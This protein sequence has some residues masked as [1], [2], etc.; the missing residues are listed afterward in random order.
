[1]K[2]AAVSSLWAFHNVLALLKI[3]GPEANFLMSSSSKLRPWHTRPVVT[4]CNQV[5]IVCS[6]A[7]PSYLFYHQSS[8]LARS[9]PFS[10]TLPSLQLTATQSH[11]SIPFHK[12]TEFRSRM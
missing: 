10:P 1:L 5:Y 3:P 12:K 9:S 4:M 7:S 8:S 6:Q 11:I 2:K